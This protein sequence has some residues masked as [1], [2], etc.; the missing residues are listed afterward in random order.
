[1][2]GASPMEGT[3]RQLSGTQ[4]EASA[5]AHRLLSDQRSNHSGAAARGLESRDLAVRVTARRRRKR[6]G[7]VPFGVEV[8]IPGLDHGIASK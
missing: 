8:T 6:R 1:M 3:V 5:R 2:T 7:W 4:F